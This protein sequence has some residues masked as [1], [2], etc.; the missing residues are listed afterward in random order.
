MESYK[1]G[2]F[3]FHRHPDLEY[4]AVKPIGPYSAGNNTL[5]GI[6]L[7]N[8]LIV[9]ENMVY[10]LTRDIGI[11]NKDEVYVMPRSSNRTGPEYGIPYSRYFLNNVKQKAEKILSSNELLHAEFLMLRHF[12][13]VPQGWSH[14]GMIWVD[15]HQIIVYDSNEWQ[16]VTTQ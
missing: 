6:T 15:Q 3:L 11:I 16:T 4:F 9:F 14:Y 10:R 1:L 2:I 7:D 13:S 5:P 12:D 8:N